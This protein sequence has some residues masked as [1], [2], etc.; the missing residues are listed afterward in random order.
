MSALQTHNLKELPYIEQIL[1]N[2]THLLG[3]FVQNLDLDDPDVKWALSE[4]VADIIRDGEGQ[5][6]AELVD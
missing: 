3:E 1:Q 4:R 5:H 6:M 2:E